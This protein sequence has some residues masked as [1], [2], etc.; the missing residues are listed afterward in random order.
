MYQIIVGNIGTVA[1]YA[2]ENQARSTFSEYV[3]ASKENQGRAAGESVTLFDGSEIVA[4][5]IGTMDSEEYDE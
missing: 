5:Y 4:E 3:L 1:E 2:T